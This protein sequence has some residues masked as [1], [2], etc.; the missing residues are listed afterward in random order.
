VE[1]GV[2][3]GVHK[4]VPDA[5]Q[6][7]GQIFDVAREELVELLEGPDVGNRLQLGEVGRPAELQSAAHGESSARGRA[8][9][10]VQQFGRLL[11]RPHER[12]PP[13]PAAGVEA[14]VVRHHAVVV[15]VDAAHR[16][17]LELSARDEGAQA[18]GG[19]G[20]RPLHLPR[21]QRVHGRQHA[22]Q[23]PSTLQLAAPPF[24][25]PL[26]EKHTGKVQKSVKMKL[27]QNHYFSNS[28]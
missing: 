10:E 26:S 14:A 20:G 4:E 5:V 11:P 16:V 15:Q 3:G 17:V 13:V 22:A 12:R 27:S 6:M 18:A 19:G 25:L 2:V 24:A 23:P 21:H 28:L 7:F 9:G 8:V 1:K